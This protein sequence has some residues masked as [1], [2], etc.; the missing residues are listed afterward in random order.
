[1]SFRINFDIKWIII[2]LLIIGGLVAANAYQYKQNDKVQTYNRQLEGNLTVVE[3]QLE[4][5]NSEIGTLNSQLLDQKNLTAYWQKN[6]EN[7]D[8]AFDAF[9]KKYNLE[10]A[11][12]DKTIADLEQQIHGGDTTVVVTNPDVCKDLSK[13]VI[14][15]SWQDTYHRFQ[16]KD[17][18]IFKKGDEN[19]TANQTFKIYG[20]VWRQK[21]GSLETRRL[22]LSEVH[23]N[24]KGDYENIPDAKAKIVSSDFKYT[25]PPALK[26]DWNWKDLFTLRGIALGSINLLPDTGNLNLGL[27][28]EFMHYKGLGLGTYTAL[29]FQHPENIAQ[30][31]SLE[32]TPKLFGKTLNVG[33][34]ASVGTPFVHFFNAYQVNAGLIFYLNN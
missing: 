4:T 29:D 1:M 25:N 27:G 21:D 20:E 33:V 5:A 8:K 3:K 28:I 24:D 2:P 15:Y 18:N 10:I 11:S 13:C 12:M 7:T 31:I 23:K 16:L 6:K 34:F 14:E 30:H 19:F 32:Y 26:T 9:K 17:P 22:V